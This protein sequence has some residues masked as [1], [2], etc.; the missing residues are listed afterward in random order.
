MAPSESGA[1][2]IKTFLSLAFIVAVIYCGFKIIPIYINDYQLNDYVQTQTPYWLTQRAPLE[3]IRK[4]ILAKA[5][6][7]SLPLGPDDMAIDANSERVQISIDYHVP[8][9]LKVYTLQ[10]HFRH[11]SA[12]SAL[13]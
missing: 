13:Q 4:S 3:G 1:G 8:V 12:N 6:S 5:D 7:L 10:L 2:T 11:S 9:D